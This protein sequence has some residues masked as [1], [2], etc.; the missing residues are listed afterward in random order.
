MTDQG[1]KDRF[2][3]VDRGDLDRQRLGTTEGE[4]NSPKP[5][6]SEEYSTLPDRNEDKS[7]MSKPSEEY[8]SP[9]DDG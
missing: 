6:N 3:G 7:A 4:V 8:S 9:R 1:S 5:Q 2:Y